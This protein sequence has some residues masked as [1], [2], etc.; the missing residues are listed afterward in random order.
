MEVGL[1]PGIDHMLAKECFDDATDKG[2]RITSY[3]S[4]TGGLPAP[5]FSDN[6]LRYKFAWSPLGVLYAALN[7]AKYRVDGK[8]V[9]V[10]TGGKLMRSAEPFDL[11]PGFNLEMIPNRDSLAYAKLYGIEDATTVQRGTLR[12]KGYCDSVWGLIQMGLFSKDPHPLL[13][14][15]GPDVTW[16]KFMCQAVGLPVDVFIGTLKDTVLKKLGQDRFKF[17]AM[18]QLQLFDDEQPLEKCGTPIETLANH[19]GKIL[20]F[21]SGERDTI[22]MTH[23][24][25]IQHQD[26][27]EEKRLV[28]LVVNGEPN[29]FSGMAKTVGYPTGIVVR[30]LL[31]D[32]IKQRGLVLPLSSGIY[33][34]ILRRLKKEGIEACEKIIL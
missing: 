27:S 7:A 8:I 33:R 17:D 23:Q 18:D 3:I 30:M 16:K 1:D 5:E 31:D 10:E 26:R 29:G 13:H 4:H 11:L 24:I 12:Y 6:P 32:E 21:N 22:I 25:T 15:G 9:E 14:P 34:P 28:Q 2:G 20:C 19:L